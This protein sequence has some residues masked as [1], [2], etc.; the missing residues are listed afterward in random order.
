MGR[1][2]RESLQWSGTRRRRKPAVQK[3]EQQ[4]LLRRGQGPPP[5]GRQSRSTSS[6]LQ[7]EGCVVEQPPPCLSLH[8]VKSI[9]TGL[10]PASMESSISLGVHLKVSK[11]RD[12][13]SSSR[14]PSVS[15]VCTPF[16]KDQKIKPRRRALFQRK[17]SDRT[18]QRS[19]LG[20]AEVPLAC[21]T[22]VLRTHQQRL[23]WHYPARLPGRSCCMWQVASRV[24]E[25]SCEMEGCSVPLTKIQ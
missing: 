6:N 25:A 22:E 23:L 9:G 16:T 20:V 13:Y 5:S 14:I 19:G 10:L 8:F 4:E 15:L 21:A 1:T 3:L 17:F 18:S 7:Q 11:G 12:V 2:Q 24:G